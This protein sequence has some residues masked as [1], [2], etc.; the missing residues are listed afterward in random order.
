MLG[1]AQ[2]NSASPNCWKPRGRQQL[3][4]A[5]SKL[6]SRHPQ[7]GPTSRGGRHLSDRKTYLQFHQATRVTPKPGF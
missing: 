3:A 5:L 2:R 7:E 1:S 4:Q 6:L